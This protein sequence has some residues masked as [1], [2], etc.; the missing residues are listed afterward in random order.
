MS[1]LI[2]KFML[3]LKL[4][5]KNRAGFVIVRNKKLNTNAFMAVGASYVFLDNYSP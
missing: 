4:S 1:K 5:L 2:N 3:W